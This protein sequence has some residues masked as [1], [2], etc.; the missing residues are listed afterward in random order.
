MDVTH[1]RIHCPGLQTQADAQ[2]ILMAL[3]NSPGFGKAKFNIG[4]QTLD[5]T[6]ANQDGGKD[7]LLKISKSGFPA[8]HSEIL[9]QSSHPG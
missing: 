1:L 5:V 3:Q 2:V 7:V 8:D 4:A 6:T 9:D